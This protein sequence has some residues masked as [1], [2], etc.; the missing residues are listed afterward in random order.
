MTFLSSSSP[1]PNHQKVSAHIFTT[2]ETASFV[3]L[4]NQLQV[5]SELVQTNLVNNNLSLAQQHANKAASL[6]TPTVLIEIAEENQKVADDLTT[7]IS[8]LQK[9]TS[10]SEKQKQGV[11]QLAQNIN[12]SLSEA[13]TMR[14]G[15]GQGQD[16]SNFLEQ[17]I[18]FLK[19]IFGGNKI[20]EE[21]DNQID[22]ESNTIK[23]LAFADLVDSI[24]I[25]Y[26]NAYAVDFDMT[27][28]SNMV[29][30]GGNSS[31]TMM[32]GMANG[33]N[34]NNS[35]IDMGSMNMSTTMMNTENK[36]NKNY[37]LVNITDFQS[38]QALGIKAS[39]IFSTELK[40]MVPKNE[41]GF[42][43]SLESGL[44]QLNNLIENKSPPMDIMMVVHTQ[45]HPNLLQAFNLRL[46]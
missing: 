16:S 2:D 46:R 18:E 39:E 32:T 41:T 44:T 9:I 11:N 10:T 31:M 38:A 17:G 42:E 24:L 34:N 26:G 6:L 43:A 8:G 29:V 23:P 14:I 12:A 45:I 40:P 19:G 20:S 35:S 5:E 25:N 7:S 22:S 4:A 13:I 1:N 3:A 27:D 28:M 15:Q 30:M 36:M 37:P 33:S 21:V